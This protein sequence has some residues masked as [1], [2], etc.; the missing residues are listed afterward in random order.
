MLPRGLIGKFQFV[1]GLVVELFPKHLLYFR[2]G[3]A[4]G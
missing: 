4:T 2:P 1:E 3:F